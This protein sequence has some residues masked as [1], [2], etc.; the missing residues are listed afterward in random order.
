MLKCFTG[1]GQAIVGSVYTAFFTEHTDYYFFFLMACST[2]VGLLSVAFIRLPPYHL[3]EYQQKHLP[4][5]ER[6]CLTNTKTQYLKQDPPAMCFRYGYAVLLF[7]I[8]Y[9]F[10]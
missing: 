6:K 3:T 7:I 5:D 2:V 1:L 8:I 9:L 10:I 4:E